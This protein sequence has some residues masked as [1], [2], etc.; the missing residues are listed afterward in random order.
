M[1]K[2]QKKISFFYLHFSSDEVY[3]DYKDKV[4]EETDKIEPSSPYSASKAG[5]D[6]ILNAYQRTF[7]FK[8]L[9][10]RPC[11]QFGVSSFLKNL[12]QQ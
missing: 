4:F 1:A 11:N 10:V 6:I 9:I 12:F 5:V 8:Y 3:G 7:D 2:L